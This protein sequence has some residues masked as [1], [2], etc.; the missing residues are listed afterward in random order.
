[1][2]HRD[3]PRPPLDAPA[4]RESLTGPGS[5]WRR[6]DI[7]GR[8]DS[9]NTDLLHRAAGG[10]DI[11][12]VVLIA[13]HQTAGRGRNGRS[14]SAAPRAQITLSAGVSAADVPS[15]AW[16]WL[17]LATGLAVVDA[18]AA[19]ADVEAGLKWPND[20]IA[21]GGKL[22]G[23]LAEVAAAK[24][25]IV[26]GIGLNVTLRRDEVPDGGATSLLEL[27]VAAPD[28]T[29]LVD[30]LL[31]ELGTRVANWRAARG[32]DTRL[33]DDYRAHS[34]TIGS[35]VRALLPGD[36][37]IVGTACS[38]DE[39]GRLRIATTDQTVAVSAGDV[40]HLRPTSRRPL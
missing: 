38:V 37:E 34:L 28:R 18:V 13:E 24:P 4:L 8:T 2:R 12:G 11:D 25:M 20:V 36:R 14:W 9:T 3:P 22:A 21:D 5:P 17:P 16:G 40:V 23:I 31:R 6:I 19:V 35:E 33:I 30:R 7:V 29:E 32:A 27:G 15:D 1:M 10:D 39:Y 26:V